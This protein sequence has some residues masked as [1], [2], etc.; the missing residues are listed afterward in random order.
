MADPRGLEYFKSGELL[1]ARHNLGGAKCFLSI[2][3]PGRISN[4]K[5]VSILADDKYLPPHAVI[6]TTRIVV[7]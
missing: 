2:Q 3:V 1:H 4:V 5:P 7:T 6:F